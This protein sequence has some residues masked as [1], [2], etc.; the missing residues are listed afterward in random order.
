MA[1][2]AV[3]IYETG[4]DTHGIARNLLFAGDDNLEDAKDLKGM[5]IGLQTE[6]DREDGTG[7]VKGGN[8][9]NGFKDHFHT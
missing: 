5:V 8:H 3:E 1:F 9:L 7:G 2:L 6:T 4:V